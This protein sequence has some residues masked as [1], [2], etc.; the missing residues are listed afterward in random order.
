MEEIEIL[1]EDEVTSDNVARLFKR[2]FMRTIIDE[3]GDVRVETDAGPKVLIS[4]DE[5]RKLLKFTTIYG[6]KDSAT[7]AEK[8]AFV[9]KMNDDMIF[10][11][12]CVADA[13]M[14]VADYF[15]PYEQ[16]I[17]AYQIVLTV[18]LFSRIVPAAIQTCD[19]DDLVE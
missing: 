5:D 8:L 1:A 15:L 6:L 13:D 19:E 14:L 10:V 12:F 18:R 4:L 7:E 17:T 9:N 3:D 11:R 16:G 2:A